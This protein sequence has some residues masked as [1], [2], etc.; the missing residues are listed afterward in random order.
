MSITA[1]IISKV[2][3]YNIIEKIYN[4]IEMSA[5]EQN[6]MDVGS[7]SLEQLQ[8]IK[9]QHEEEVQELRRQLQALYGVKNRF[10]SAK[11][12]V[13]E[14]IRT[15]NGGKEILIPLTSSLYVPGKIVDPNKV[16]VELGTGFFCEKTSEGA[17]ALMERKITLVNSSIETIDGVMVQK[18][19]NIDAVI[20]VMNYKIRL[21]QQGRGASQKA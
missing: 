14:L 19:K 8:S 4:I 18:T 2:E 15:D 9:V 3:E 20:E 7:M 17:K 10:L 5:A 1:I 16:I 11:S 6:Q 12:A 21:Y 13:D